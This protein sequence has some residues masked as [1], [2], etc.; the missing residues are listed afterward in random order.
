M[1]TLRSFP[2]LKLPQKYRLFTDAEVFTLSY[3]FFMEYLFLCHHNTSHQ[4]CDSKLPQFVAGR[5][6]PLSSAH[7]AR[8]FFHSISGQRKRPQFVTNLCRTV[9]RARFRSLHRRAVYERPRPHGRVRPGPDG[10]THKVIYFFSCKYT[11]IRYTHLNYY[12]KST[13]V[14][15]ACNF[16]IRCCYVKQKITR[17]PQIHRSIVIEYKE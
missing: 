14:S 2:V 15:C 3:V 7:P 10:R 12:G 13:R 16:E 4:N 11:A 9:F 17:K 1:S 8:S 6:F 5:R